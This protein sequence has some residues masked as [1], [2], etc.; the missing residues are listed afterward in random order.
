MSNASN[1][2]ESPQLEYT[3][4]EGKFSAKIYSRELLF[5]Y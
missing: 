1:E 3:V 5:S 4:H 2:S